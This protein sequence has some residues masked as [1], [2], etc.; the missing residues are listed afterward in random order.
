M[1][2]FH[3]ESPANLYMYPQI[4]YVS[5]LDRGTPYHYNEANY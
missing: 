2:V 1:V 5:M 3:K 4:K